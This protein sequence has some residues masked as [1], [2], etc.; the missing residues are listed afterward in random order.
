MEKFTFLQYPLC[1]TCRK[2]KKW[3]DENGV[4]YNSRLIV[5]NNPTIE[6]LKEWIP[7][8]GLPVKK[9]FNTSGQVYKE[10]NLKDKLP[11]MTEEEQ[12]ELLATNG[13]LV[14]RPL[15]VS[16]D[17]VLVGFKQEDW[18]KIK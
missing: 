18:E 16:D 12:I 7:K 6:E 5:E 14:K 3:L 2:A 11:N 15:M 13:K 4:N 9:F 1:G 10:L 17:T 8:S